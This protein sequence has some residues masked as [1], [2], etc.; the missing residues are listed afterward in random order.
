MNLNRIFRNQSWS[1]IGISIFILIICC[2][3]EEQFHLWT[4]IL[5]ILLMFVLLIFIGYKFNPFRIRKKNTNKER[6]NNYE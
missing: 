2:L 6:I 5:S 4:S 3:K 1:F